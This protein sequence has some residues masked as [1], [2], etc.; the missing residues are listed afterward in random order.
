MRFIA[1]FCASL[2]FCLT[3]H[4]MRLA[5]SAPQFSEESQPRILGRPTLHHAK[6]LPTR[7][8][9]HTKKTHNQYQF[10]LSPKQSSNADAH[11]YATSQHSTTYRYNPN[12]T[13]IAY[14]RHKTKYAPESPRPIRERHKKSCVCLR[15]ALSYLGVNLK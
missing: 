12:A 5:K 7:L 2:T 9:S 3:V 15:T 1:L 13:R 14:L 6:S 10:L 8:P 4:P 11:V